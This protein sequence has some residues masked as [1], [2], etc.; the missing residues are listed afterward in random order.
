MLKEKNHDL[1]YKQLLNKYNYNKQPKIL[2]IIYVIMSTLVE[3]KTI[4]S[5]NKTR[6]V[7]I[8]KIFKEQC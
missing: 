2:F 4:E 8:L 6:Q 1:F 3:I 5:L 7:E